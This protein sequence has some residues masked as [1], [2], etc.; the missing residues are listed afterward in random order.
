M[1]VCVRASNETQSV[2]QRATEYSR[3][4]NHI[5]VELAEQATETI[6]PG[7]LPGDAL[8]TSPADML[9]QI[10]TEYKEICQKEQLSSWNW[11]T[12]LFM[13]IRLAEENTLMEHLLTRHSAFVIEVLQHIRFIDLRTR[14][15]SGVVAAVGR[16]GP[17]IKSWEIEQWGTGEKLVE[18]L[19]ML[20]RRRLCNLT[21]RETT[22]VMTG[23]ADLQ[24]HAAAQF[25]PVL[26]TT[27]RARRSNFKPA[28]LCQLGWALGRLGVPDAQELM[29]SLAG[30]IRQKL[31]SVTPLELAH[32]VWACGNVRVRISPATMHSI[33]MK[34]EA[35]IQLL[36]PED[37]ADVLWALSRIPFRPRFEFLDRMEVY[38]AN[39][40]STFQPCDIS[41]SLYAFAVFSYAPQTL[42][43]VTKAFILDYQ[44]SFTLKDYCQVI[45]SLSIL[46]ALD[47]TFLKLA[48]QRMVEMKTQRGSGDDPYGL[49]GDSLRQIYHCLLHQ[50]ILK[51]EKADALLPDDIRTQCYEAWSAFHC[52][53]SIHPIVSHVLYNFE[54]M[55]YTEDCP[56]VD[57][58]TG[59][60]LYGVRNAN[61]IRIVIEVV[62]EDSCFV[63]ERHRLQ[64]PQKW[65]HR[66]LKECGWPLLIIYEDVW[67]ALDFQEQVEYLTENVL[68]FIE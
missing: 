64:G 31:S 62:S 20:V 67:M 12:L 28:E 65:R 6:S 51:K 17:R 22:V 35:N 27:C 10:V 13:L 18:D 9:D 30:T 58:L 1:Q 36:K 52:Q 44:E 4:V 5:L 53:S 8:F 37:V 57:P 63:N 32:F 49:D 61:G 23:L 21:P 42:L 43:Q 7:N 15:F 16:L 38:F 46:D 19:A 29:E 34:I 66:I 60:M 56:M 2:R 54:Y 26:T 59:W 45:W 48:V 47:G 14:R 25:V 40:I 41:R 33:V 11:S 55:G 50:S 39:R 24:Y 3:K 68:P